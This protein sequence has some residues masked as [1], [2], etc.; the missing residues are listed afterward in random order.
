MSSARG[1]GGAARLLNTTAYVSLLS[2]DCAW[3]LS[4]LH[5]TF[6]TRTNP[7]TLRGL[8][9]ALS[10][11]A[12]HSHYSVLSLQ[13]KTKARLK[14]SPILSDA[15]PACCGLNEILKG[16][17]MMPPRYSNKKKRNCDKTFVRHN[18]P[19]TTEKSYRRYYKVLGV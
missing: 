7:E 1:G 19:K 18:R 14:V 3:F 15:S 6:I 2:V 12:L 4:Q 10:E 5:H 11:G 13:L 16:H 9:R 8:A 17:V